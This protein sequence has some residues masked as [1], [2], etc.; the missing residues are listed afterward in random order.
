MVK[1]VGLYLLVSVL[2]LAANA[3]WHSVPT[4]VALL[5]VLLPFGVVL[6]LVWL[7]CLA[8]A[9]VVG[10]ILLT[11]GAISVADYQTKPKVNEKDSQTA[12]AQIS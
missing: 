7:L 10:L 11:A 8:G 12:V 6:F 1:K 9:I 3:Y 4:W 2:L 5:P